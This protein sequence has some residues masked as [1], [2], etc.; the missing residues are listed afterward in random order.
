MKTKPNK[1]RTIEAR[2]SINLSIGIYN[3]K[4]MTTYGKIHELEGE[5]TD[6]K[7]D[8]NWPIRN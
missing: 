6:M 3:D 7:W 8:I 1:M 2:K 4:S 5:L